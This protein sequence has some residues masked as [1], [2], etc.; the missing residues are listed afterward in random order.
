[1]EPT[2]LDEEPTF[3]GEE[4]TFLGEEQTKGRGKLCVWAAQKGRYT[5][6]NRQPPRASGLRPY[7]LTPFANPKKH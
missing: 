5:V 7:A 2:F 6:A 1:M 4:L 3:L